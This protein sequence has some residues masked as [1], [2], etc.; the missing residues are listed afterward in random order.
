MLPMLHRDVI[1]AK[2]GKE[3]ITDKMFY[4]E[5]NRA[6]N[7]IEELR[8]SP[9]NLDI[10]SEINLY[11]AVLESVINDSIIKQM[12]KRYKLQ[13]SNNFVAD[14]I[15]KSGVFNNSN[16]EFDRQKF[17]ESLANSNTGFKE[18]DYINN[19]KN[20]M[21]SI[22]INSYL[23]YF[24]FNFPNIADRMY[25]SIHQIREIEKFSISKDTVVPNK[26][27]TNE[28]LEKF[29]ND[30]KFRYIV[31]EYRS[32]DYAIFDYDTIEIDEDIID[33]SSI[34]SDIKKNKLDLI[35]QYQYIK[36]NELENAKE[37]LNSINNTKK[38][39]AEHTGVSDIYTSNLES[40][41]NIAIFDFLFHTDQPKISDI[42]SD[43]ESFFIINL[44]SISNLSE[45]D[46][47]NIKKEI[48]LKLVNEKKSEYINEIRKELQNSIDS[49]DIETNKQL[50][51]KFSK[52]YKVKIN[53][54][55]PINVYGKL[56]NNKSS[57]YYLG[58]KEEEKESIIN[59]MFQINNEGARIVEFA[60]Q[61]NNGFIVL[62]I[63]NVI[64]QIQKSFNK[65]ISDVTQD[66]IANY[67][68]E[69]LKST[70]LT[71]AKQNRGITQD[72]ASYTKETVFR[73]EMA[74]I[75]Q[76]GTN[77]LPIELVE[78]VFKIN[79]GEFTEIIEYNDDYI[80]AR[81]VEI[82]KHENT[83]EKEQ[84]IKERIL[85]NTSDIVTQIIQ[86]STLEFLRNEEFKT[87]ILD[88]NFDNIKK[89]ISYAISVN[90]NKQE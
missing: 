90:S 66:F 30:N 76:Y 27:P 84:H 58:I 20:A 86:R 42:I 63:T 79:I 89:Q 31:H 35:Y 11:N 55:G 54:I 49:S 70:L 16:G 46:F 37:I 41:N 24:H 1:I 57:D 80:L 10:I 17:E 22:L 34:E 2:V 88:K 39:F 69:Y 5:F 33:D 59:T 3:K 44:I 7:Y 8:K 23:G 52:K 38:S 51:Q 62:Y 74:L 32:A 81:L 68:K 82:K 19:I 6:V 29:Y 85:E 28:E 21:I 40:T 83:K 71:M 87:K 15:K 64:P 26:K 43:G 53:K 48:K 75:G 56:R 78:N 18:I 60:E 47:D 61:S 4:N 36:T 65:A 73:P 25:N 13:I 9:I 45:Y 14:E 12:I 67:K 72:K 77:N 50:I